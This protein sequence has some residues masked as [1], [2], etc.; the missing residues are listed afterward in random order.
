MRLPGAGF[1]LTVNNKLTVVGT[2]PLLHR[3]ELTDADEV[4]CNKCR[5]DGAALGLNPP[6]QPIGT[7]TVKFD[8]GRGLMP[9]DA[10][11]TGVIMTCSDDLTLTNSARLFVSG[12]LSFPSGEAGYGALVNVGKD[13]LLGNNSWIVPVSHPTN[14][15]AVLLCMRNLKVSQSGGIDADYG[16]YVGYKPQPLGPGRSSHATSGAGYG[17]VG[18]VGV[19]APLGS[20]G[21]AYGSSNAPVQSGSGGMPPKNNTWY[22]GWGGGSVQIRATETVDVQ[23]T[24]TANGGTGTSGDSGAAS[25]GAIYIQCATFIGHSNGVLRA[26]GG[27]GSVTKGAGGGGGRIAVWRVQ[28]RS[29]SDIAS[30]VDGGGAV[31]SAQYGENGTIVWGWLPPPGTV[32]SIR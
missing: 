10:A 7:E 9:D 3:L 23:G 21:P 26:N 32:L 25:G 4:S 31:A 18:G 19:G 12:G 15:A 2:D 13:V 30:T 20:G 5:I 11:V 28:D 14:G 27:A 8:Y 22:G 29:T 6:S 17:G 16:G 1:R 24:F